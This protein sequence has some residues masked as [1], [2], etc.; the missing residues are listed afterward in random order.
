[1]EWVKWCCYCCCCC[2]VDG[3]AIENFFTFS[4]KQKFTM[5]TSVLKSSLQRPVG[6]SVSTRQ[7]QHCFNSID[8]VSC[9]YKWNAMTSVQPGTG[10]KTSGGSGNWKWDRHENDH[11]SVSGRLMSDRSEVFCQPQKI[12]LKGLWVI[13]EAV[14]NQL[15]PFLRHALFDS[16]DDTSDAKRRKQS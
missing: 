2:V 14:Q 11:Q 5:E 12:S 6:S 9:P 8:F 4:L 10:F 16:C 1:M 7:R 13:L 15:V 3:T